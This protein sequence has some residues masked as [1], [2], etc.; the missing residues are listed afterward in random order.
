[1][2]HGPYG[3]VD[4]HL[5]G[6]GLVR[7]MHSL[8]EAR[9]LTTISTK[10]QATVSLMHLLSTHAWLLTG[11]ALGLGGAAVLARCR[12]SLRATASL[13]WILVGSKSTPGSYLRWWVSG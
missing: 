4:R 13:H 10:E 1:M 11:L 2:Y 6:R 8:L 12:I 3:K 9:H 7:E 5:L